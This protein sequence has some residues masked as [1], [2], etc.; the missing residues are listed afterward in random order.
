MY[1]SPYITSVS[2]SHARSFVCLLIT[3]CFIIGKP[4]GW[5]GNRHVA[6]VHAHTARER[7]R[8]Y[9]GIVALGW[10]AKQQQQERK[11]T[12]LLRPK[13][14][15]RRR[16]NESETEIEIARG[17]VSAWESEWA[18][19]YSVDV[20]DHLDYTHVFVCMCVCVSDCVTVCR[21]S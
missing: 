5:N 11:K 10:W 3:Q 16:M 19:L 18:P 20:S 4:H 13:W 14:T 17:R 2:F 15:E 8:L 1:A 12:F 9:W 7:E 21:Y 6:T